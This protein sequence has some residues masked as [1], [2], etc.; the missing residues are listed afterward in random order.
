[1]SNE[2]ENGNPTLESAEEQVAGPP[3]ESPEEEPLEQED[4]DVASV[5]DP[6]VRLEA[7]TAERDRLASENENLQDRL[8]RRQADF[9]NFR[10]RVEKER[11]EFLQYAG[12][13]SVRALL[14]V[15]DDFDRALQAAGGEE[16]PDQEYV[17]GVEMIYQ[18]F[19]E[20]LKQLGLE[21]I[22]SVGQP[23]DP[24][25]HH[26]VETV[27]TEETEDHTI[28]EEFQRGYN[29]RGRLLREAMV[30]VAVRPS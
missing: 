14:P 25:V 24:N 4:L 5:E 29:F 21:P 11:A 9:E 12:M 19:F 7:V 10:R 23:F 17:K 27:Q 3:E 28:L 8:L 1:V 30:K 13:E 18:R 20:A 26:A 22:E 16:G 6:A 15:L 2:K